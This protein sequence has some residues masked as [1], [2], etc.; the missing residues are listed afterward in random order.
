VKWGFLNNNAALWITALVCVLY[1][2]GQPVIDLGTLGGSRGYAFGINN[3]NQIVGNADLPSGSSHAFLWSNGAMTDLGTLGG[4]YSAA[5]GINNHGAIVGYS[6][7][8]SGPQH[9]FVAY[10]QNRLVDLNS[11]LDASGAG[12][13]I[14][15]A[16]GINDI[17]QIAADA[18]INGATH[19]VLLT[20]NGT[21][22]C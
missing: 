14:T 13:T 10:C 16:W 5:T 2:P 4:T 19:A 1:I 17:G 6:T 12:Y 22:S 18:T 7:T 9:G 11:M 8:T 20:F 3:Y 21:L 15:V